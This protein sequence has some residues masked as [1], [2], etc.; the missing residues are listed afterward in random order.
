[1]S[2]FTVALIAVLVAAGGCSDSNPDTSATS[3]AEAE[4][5]LATAL[6]RGTTSTVDTISGSNQLAPVCVVGADGWLQ[7]PDGW[8]R[9]EPVYT[10]ANADLREQV[11]QFAEALGGFELLWSDPNRD[12]WIHVGFV[13]TDIVQRQ[14]ELE[15]QFPGEGIVA[16]PLD[17]AGQELADMAAQVDELL[18]S[19]MAVFHTNVRAGTIEIWTGKVTDEDRTFLGTLLDRYPVC[20]TAYTNE[21]VGEAGPQQPSGD[22]WRYLTQVDRSLGQRTRFV[23]T[24]L[25]LEELWDDL[26]LEPPVPDVDWY[27][28]IVV[29]FEI[30]YSGSCPDTRFDGITTGVGE[31]YPITAGPTTL[32]A[33]PQQ[34]CTADYNPRIYIV[35]VARDLLPAPPLLIKTGPEVVEEI[36]T[37]IDLRVPG[38]TL[39]S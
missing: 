34:T 6:A 25:G 26:G 11:R 3:V 4:P 32:N 16:V 7:A 37:D 28:N 18:P 8:Y 22:G 31:T 21:Q 1:M 2:R 29:A 5:L 33:S 13:R 19:D 36:T 24:D 12:Y 23:T 39:D 9:D 20:T 27:D 15:K 30:G 10:P 35:A 14:E 17:Y 38:S